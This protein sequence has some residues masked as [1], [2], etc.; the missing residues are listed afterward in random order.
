[1][2]LGICV[3]VTT[4]LGTRV[5]VALLVSQVLHSRAQGESEIHCIPG[6][7]YDRDPGEVPSHQGMRF[8]GSEPDVPVEGEGRLALRRDERD[9]E[10]LS[11]IH[12]E[13][14]HSDDI[15]IF[16]ASPTSSLILRQVLALGPVHRRRRSLLVPPMFVPENQRAPF[17]RSIGMV[18][19]KCPGTTPSFY[20]HLP[21]PEMASAC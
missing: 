4:A 17:P 7:E 5:L 21:F 6:V 2:A 13:T 1:M 18:R 20:L 16:K 14:A 19:L 8:K 15:T 10:A 12:G 11:I 9:G 3:H